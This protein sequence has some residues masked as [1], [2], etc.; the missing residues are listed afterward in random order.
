VCKRGC[1]GWE[2]K[3]KGKDL[4]AAYAQL[5]RYAPA[6]ENPPLLVVC[7]LARFEIHTNW[8][9]TVSHTYEIGLDELADPRKLRWL[10]WAFTDPE[11]LKPGLT[12]QTLTEQAAAEFARLAQRLRNRGHPSQMV[13]HFINRLVF[14]M[15][16]EDVDLLPD[17]GEC[18]PLPGRV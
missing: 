9:N 13:A 16:A 5:Q 17:A 15:F 6:L 3:S 1:F 7:D 2:C 10:K 8:T 18:R 4:K 11:Q 12:R 14:C